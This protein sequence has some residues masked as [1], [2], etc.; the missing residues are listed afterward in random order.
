MKT[1]YIVSKSKADKILIN[2][3]FMPVNGKTLNRMKYCN[4]KFKVN[5]FPVGRQIEAHDGVHAIYATK[6]KDSD[7]EYSRLM[8]ICE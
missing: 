5:A 2:S 1:L 8:C 7:G 4:A 3:L 6:G